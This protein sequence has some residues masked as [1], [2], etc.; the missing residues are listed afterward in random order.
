MSPPSLLTSTPLRSHELHILPFVDGAPDALQ[1]IARTPR[2]TDLETIPIESFVRTPDGSAVA[3]VRKGG[4]GEIY[5]RDGSGRFLV[6]GVWEGQGQVVLFDKG[7]WAYFKCLLHIVFNQEYAFSGQGLALH[8]AGTLTIYLYTLGA[9][10]PTNAVSMI[11]SPSSTPRFL[12]LPSSSSITSIL[13]LTPNSIS[14][15]H[16]DRNA[17]PPTLHLQSSSALPLPEIPSLILPVD[18]MAWA[19]KPRRS[20]TLSVSSPAVSPARNDDNSSLAKHDALVSISDQG[21]LS[22]WVPDATSQGTKPEWVCTGSIATNRKGI[23]LARCSSAKK[24]ALGIFLIFCYLGALTNAFLS[25]S[26]LIGRRC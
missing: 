23:R 1:R 16:F 9:S 8:A 14:M 2:V 25:T 6:S 7:M 21:H 15:F 13:A 22:F 10:K 4:G 12:A 19:H 26:S 24:T 17:S 11:Y 5:S 20:R 3:S 18:P